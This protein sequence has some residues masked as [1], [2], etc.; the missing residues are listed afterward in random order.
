MFRVSGQKLQ[1]NTDD[2]FARRI[3]SEKGEVRVRLQRLADARH[4]LD[5][6]VIAVPCTLHR[7]ER[8]R[9][10]QMKT[11]EDAFAERRKGKGGNCKKRERKKKYTIG[12]EFGDRKTTSE[13]F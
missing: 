11:E 1:K 10:S 9:C 13:L 8:C 3:D 2:R 6:P 5:Y 7:N 4:A 12:D